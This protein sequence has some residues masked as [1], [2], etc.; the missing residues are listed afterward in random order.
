MSARER[1]ASVSIQFRLIIHISMN[2]QDLTKD[3]RLFLDNLFK[4]ITELE[5]KRESTSKSQDDFSSSI[6]DTTQTNQS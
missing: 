4:N 1:P 6:D 5:N 2:E 3:N